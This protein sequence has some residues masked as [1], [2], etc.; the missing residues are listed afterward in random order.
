MANTAGKRLYSF[1]EVYLIYYHMIRTYPYMSVAKRKKELSL[2]FIER[3]MMAVTEVNGCALCSFAHTKMA[4]EAGMNAGEIKNILAGAY[5]D[6][7]A[8]EIDAILF[9]QHYAE[10]RGKPSKQSWDRLLQVY[11]EHKAM[12]ILGTTRAIYFGNV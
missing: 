1:K 10:S 9:A 4:L 6:V 5:E 2:H 7:P 11:G 12:G 3:I 8:D